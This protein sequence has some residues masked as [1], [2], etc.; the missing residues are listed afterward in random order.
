[1]KTL[2]K[3]E[4]F[5]ASASASLGFLEKAMG[6]SPSK[7]IQVFPTDPS[8]STL[9]SCFPSPGP[10]DLGTCDVTTRTTRSPQTALYLLYWPFWGEDEN[11]NEGR[12]P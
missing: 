9:G 2:V 5:G 3:H 1:M 11:Q 8:Y 10:E 7:A 6:P 12:D 4:T